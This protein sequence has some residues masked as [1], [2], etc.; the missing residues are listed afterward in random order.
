MRFR[1][2]SHWIIAVSWWEVIARSAGFLMFMIENVKSISWA[3]LQHV[4]IL[5]LVPFVHAISTQRY[6][7]AKSMANKLC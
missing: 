4:V 7:G 3:P 1:D 5:V 6:D 2:E